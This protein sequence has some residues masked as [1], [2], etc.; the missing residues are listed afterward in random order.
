MGINAETGEVVEFVNFTDRDVIFD[1]LINL[2]FLSDGRIIAVT[3]SSAS[4]MKGLSPN[5]LFLLS[6]IPAHEYQER[7]ELTLFGYEIDS[8]VKNAVVEFNQTS[9]TYRIQMTDYAQFNQRE[10]D[11]AGLTKLATELIAGNVPDILALA[12]LPFRQYAEKGLLVDLNEYFDDD[13]EIDKADYFENIMHAA[14]TDGALYR[15]FPA[16]VISSLIGNPEVL[17][18]SP[19]WTLNEFKAVLNANPKADIPLGEWMTKLRFMNLTFLH[20][21]EQFVDWDSGTVHFDSDEFIELLKLS[22]LFPLESDDNRP[23]PTTMST[24]ETIVTG[25]QLMA[26]GQLVRVM[27]FMIDRTFFGGGIT[28][29]GFPGDNG[30]GGMFSISGDVA[31]TAQSKHKQ[32]AWEFVRLLLSE[33]FVRDNVNESYIGLPVHSVIFE[34]Q[35]AYAMDSWM[36]RQFGLVDPITGQSLAIPVLSA[37]EAGQIRALID[38]IDGVLDRDEMLRNIISESASDFFN[39]QTTASDAA[40]VIQSR[41]SIYMS[42]QR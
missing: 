40:R 22:D 2:A 39:G 6:K 35:I 15:V 5:E 8:I 29:K 19:G 9:K 24:V 11:S 38:S 26:W 3:R 14:Q 1:H 17:G 34:E 31:I 36:D 37:E 33:D 23:Y 41:A 42:E 28:F 12:N 13:P 7:T 16:F 32:E 30:R 27:D 25:R 18:S 10:G 20:N 21:I 4:L